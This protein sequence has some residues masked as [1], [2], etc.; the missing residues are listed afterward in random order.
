MSDLKPERRKAIDEGDSPKNG[1]DLKYYF[2][3]LILSG[4][5]L[6]SETFE[7]VFD[8]FW[9]FSEQQYPVINEMA[10]A[11]FNCALEF[12]LRG[13]TNKYRVGLTA[14]GAGYMDWYGRVARAY[15]NARVAENGDVFL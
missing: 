9:K 8:E 7:Q 5:V 10:G 12:Q 1:G 2:A 11:T 14:L 13:L 6:K 3:S 4:R 15:G